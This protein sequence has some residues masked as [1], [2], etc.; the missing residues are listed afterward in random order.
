MLVLK[1]L[2]LLAAAVLSFVVIKMLMVRNL[3]PV[4][5]KANRSNR[6]PQQMRR[7]RQDPRTGIYYPEG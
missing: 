7:L 3:Q 4:R 1:L 6:Q 5:V 2:S